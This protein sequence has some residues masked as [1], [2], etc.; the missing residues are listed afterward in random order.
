M[1]APSHSSEELKQIQNTWVALQRLTL[2]AVNA[3]TLQNLI[4]IIVN[5]TFQVMKYDRA[6]F[7]SKRQDTVDLLGVSGL[8]N[9]NAQTEV[10][11]HL[12]QAIQ[13]LKNQEVARILTPEDFSSPED[14]NYIQSLRA[15][16][17]YWLPF[18]VENEELGLW[19]EIYDDPKVATTLFQNYSPLLKDFVAPAF[20]TAFHQVKHPSWR[21]V[22]P[23]FNKRNLGIAALVLFLLLTVVPIRLRIVA[24]CE[25]VSTNAF[26]LAA[27]LDGII[28]EVLVK[29]GEEV[30]KN[31]ILYEYDKKIPKY[32][33]QATEKEVEI[34]QAELNQS[35]AL[36]TQNPD[37]ATKLGLLDIKL[38]KSKDE[39]KFIKEQISHLTGISPLNGLVSMDNPDEWRGRPVKVGE[40]IMTISN[41][42]ETK[43]RIWIPEHDNIVF[44]KDVP[45]HVFLNT[46][47]TKTFEAELV[48]IS[49][50]VK[51]MEGELPSYEAEAKWLSKETPKLGLKGSAV[52]YGE[53]VSILYYLFRK[54]IG[55]VRKFLGV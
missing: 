18:K 10:T 41:E 2:K 29:P 39:L 26:V 24:P 28:E 44:D 13:K 15:S 4:F 9:L 1:Q 49:P 51:V 52:L 27:P 45:V 48:F 14:W 23:Y 35:Y 11:T 34:L 38:K 37:E 55:A 5:D 40:K 46:I 17:V 22:S 42:G 21:K 43:L 25:V 33:L 50:E 31:Q 54:P 53:R 6:L 16:T 47:P 12:K 30:K 20:A 36:G 19:F 7:F 8:T 32:K 3:K